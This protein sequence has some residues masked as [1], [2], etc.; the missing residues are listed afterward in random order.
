MAKAEREKRIRSPKKAA[1]GALVGLGGA[2]LAIVLWLTGALD[3]FELKTWDARVRLLARA[4][5]ASESIALILLDQNSLDWG[6]EVVG[7]PWPWPRE[8]YAAVTRFCARAGARAL[9]FDV[10]YTEPSSFGVYDDESFGAAAA[11]YGRVVAS[12][13]LSDETG[14]AL[15]WPVPVPR[16]EVS[17]KG[18]PMWQSRGLTDPLT[19]SR[20]SFPIPELAGNVKML[21]NVNLTRAADLDGI[22][23]RAPLLGFFDDSALPT[24]GLASY[25]AP[26]P[27]A[28]SL[29]L[30]PGSA[31]VG[32]LNVPVDRSGRVLLR[33]AG[34][35]EVYRPLSAAAVIQSEL[36]IEAG[37]TPTIDPESLR[38]RYVLFGFSAPGLYDL[39]SSPVSGTYPGVGVHA[40]LL[41]NLLSGEF[42]SD[43]PI[44]ATVLL[45]LALS[46][47]AGLASVY[48]SGAARSILVYVLFL[49]VPL[50]LSL[51]GYVL[52][53]WLPLLVIEVGVAATLVSGG[54][55]NYATEGRQKRYLKSAFRQYLS[56]T[57]IEELIAHPDRLKLGGE[58]RDLSIFFS[59]LQG[60]TTIS[61]ALT[62]E[63]LTALL[64]DYLSAMT[65]IIQEEGGTIDKYEGDAIIAFWNAPVEQLDH[66]LRAVR[67]ALRCQ[68]RLAELRPAFR[69]RAGKDLFMRIGL[70]SGPAVV[71]NMGSRTRF[72][73]TMLGDAV[74]LA[75]RLEGINKQFRTYTMVSAATR[76]AMDEA[77]PSRELARVA[78]VGKSKAVVVYEPMLPEDWTA[79]KPILESFTAALAAFYDG[80]FGEAESLFGRTASEDPPAAA[81]VAKCRELQARAPEGPWNGVWVMTSK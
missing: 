80:R 9:A 43:V 64:N 26:L 30:K 81:Y 16:P 77:F 66:A 46:V 57:V 6:K 76:E 53:R 8:T 7:L 78:V 33:Y 35:L 56:P 22:Y 27:G 62:P 54:L 55:L 48:A 37:E 28:A 68:K 72:D 58:R 32:E 42:M 40:T 47:G 20:A 11:D 17:V 79:R 74:N 71:G 59:D 14:D 15:R 2:A 49:A 38:N 73:Y 44:W 29:E 41:D 10:L 36:Q 25:L 60:F 21:A 50:G 12:V 4:S 61:E 34:S 70:N 67:A 75:A 52:G 19:F 63:E 5:P 23:R 3:L 31:G 45:V 69:E 39:R 65:D 24:L 13:F 18:L 51:G 1:L